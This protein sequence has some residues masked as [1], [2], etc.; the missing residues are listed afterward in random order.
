MNRILSWAI[1]TT[2]I[3]CCGSVHAQFS[4]DTQVLQSHTGAGSYGWAVSELTDINGDGITDYIIGATG[5][6]TTDVFSGADGQLIHR[7]TLPGSSLGYAMADA[8]DV[9]NDGVHDI[10]TGGTLL[11][12]SRGVAVVY[13]GAT[14]AQLWRFDGEQAGD[15]LGSAVASA[16]D[17]NG[18][19]FADVLV[20]AESYAPNNIEAGRVYVYSGQDGQLIR[21]LDAAANR[22]R[23]GGGVGL[24]GDL[25]Q[26]GIHE[27]IVGAYDAGTNRGGQAYVYSGIDG[28]LLFTLL[29]DPGA[30]AYGQFFV[31][32]AGD[33]DHD[34]TH[35]IYVGDYNH[36]GG[37]GRV[38]IYSGANQ[39]VIHRFSGQAGEGVG[40]GRRA[41]DVNGDGHADLIVGSYTAGPNQAGKV[42]VFSG[43]DGSVLQVM[44]HNLA[45][46]QLGFDAVGLGDV[47]QD[48]KDDHLL[49][50]ANG[51]VVYVVAGT[52]AKPDLQTFAINP[53]LSGAWGIEGADSQGLMFDIND[54]LSFVFGAWFTYADGTASQTTDHAAGVKTIGAPEHLWL[55]A[56]GSYEGAQAPLTLAL[57]SDG[58]FVDP[59]PTGLTEV[60]TAELTFSDCQH[61]SL[62]YDLAIPDGLVASGQLNLFRL[63]PDRFCQ[64][65]QST[66]DE[67]PSIT[68]KHSLK[69]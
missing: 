28:Q 4:D 45:N 5:T 21:T 25:N 12:G 13:S 39:Q 57:S 51:N 42:T 55:T 53:G 64:N 35:D 65:L 41:G 40:P 34:G 50:A 47:N 48:G 36:A 23:F 44:Q 46:S 19:G 58:L 49:S 17:V 14:G 3:L 52:V 67:P 56:Y 15:R 30:S 59:S 6:H 66:V 20:G 27:F 63:T 69:H 38:Y 9:D 54:Q 10:I 37:R 62:T 18:D 22:D 43:A 68:H 60:G 1:T 26:D 7:F 31:A 16:G 8:G 33:V 61:G 24:L 2:M 11:N 29:P 32:D